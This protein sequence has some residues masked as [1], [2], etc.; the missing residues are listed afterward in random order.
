MKYLIPILIILLIPY[1]ELFSQPVYGVDTN[2][3]DYRVTKEYEIANIKVIGQGGIKEHFVITRS[4]LQPGDKIAIPGDAIANAIR[5]LWRTGLF[6]NVEIYK[7][8][9]N[10]PGVVFMII[11]VK[12]RG[13]LTTYSLVGIKEMEKDDIKE[14]IRLTKNDPITEFDKNKIANIIENHYIDKGY[15]F[16][17]VEVIEKPDTSKD[18]G[19]KLI[20]N[21]DIGKKVKINEVNIYGNNSIADGK[22]LKSLKNTKGKSKIETDPKKYFQSDDPDYH[23][24]FFD[25]LGSISTKNVASVFEDKVTLHIFNSSKFTYEKFIEDKNKLIEFYNSQGFRD[26][27]ISVDSIVKLDEANININITINEGKRYYFGNITWVGNQK[28]PDEILNLFLDIPKGAIYNRSKLQ[29]KLFFDPSGGADISSLYMDDGYLFFQVTPKEV[30]VVGDSID[31]EIRVIEGPQAIIDK[32][33]IKGNDKTSEKVV[34][35]EL[36]TIPGNKFSRTDII[37][38]QREIAALGYFDPEQIGIVPMPHPESG[39]VDIEYTVVE[40]PSDQIELSAGWGGQVGGIYGSAGIVFNNFSL[41]KLFSPIAWSKGLPGGDGQK[42][43][44]RVQ[45]QGKRLQSYT[46]SFTEPWLGGKKPNSFSTSFNY[47][48]YNPSGLPRESDFASWYS[49]KSVTVGIGKRLKWPDDYFFLNSSISYTNYELKNYG[50]F[51][52]STGISNNFYLTETLSRV[53]TS[54]NPYFPTGGSSISLMMQLTPPFSL[55]RG[56]EELPSANKYKWVEYHKWRFTAEWYNTLLGGKSENSRK[57][58][59]R[60]AAKLGFVGAYNKEVTGISPFERFRVGGDGLSGGFTLQGYDII[61]LRG[62]PAPIAPVGG[63]AADGLNAPVFNKF[64]LEL[65][66]P[67]TP[68][69]SQVSTIYAMFFLE[70]GNSYADFEYYDPFL[71]R[72]SFGF[73]IRLFLPMFGLL[74]FDYGIPFGDYRGAKIGDVLGRGEFHFRLGFEPD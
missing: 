64:T 26:A 56:D 4:G 51:V 1:S 17:N 30:R 42:L 68:P 22:L 43:S 44:F 67:L 49:S 57:L 63:R 36:R 19:I 27:T 66:Y 53:S 35:R 55:F 72:N 45:T 11:K 15:L 14:K 6:S 31:V 12:E 5:K 13:R 3:V 41:R 10:Y 39:T 37:R 70:G 29:E 65:R 20:I 74:G 21:I 34:R 16:T 48:F 52:V 54:G 71:L 18:N 60:L 58:V 46:F 73:G 23:F 50:D 47:T 32:I 38:S 62:T 7:E 33:I 25:A 61:A 40:K 9:K 59:L 8:D 69:Q 24:N 28:Y 2:T